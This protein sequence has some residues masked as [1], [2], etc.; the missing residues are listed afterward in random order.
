MAPGEHARSSFRNILIWCYADLCSK[1]TEIFPSDGSTGIH[2]L[3]QT[4]WMTLTRW[5]P[6]R[7][8]TICYKHP[9]LLKS[10]STHDTATALRLMHSEWVDHEQRPS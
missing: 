3:P 10:K 8:M 1:D 5:L 2:A 4:F 7:R 6:A 9:P